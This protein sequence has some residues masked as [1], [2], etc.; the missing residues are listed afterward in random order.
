MKYREFVLWCGE[1]ATD[2]CWDFETAT[3]CIRIINVMQGIPFRKKR[4]A[5]REI[6]DSVEKA[7]VLPINKKIRDLKGGEAE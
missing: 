3:L 6:Q 4:K 1:R 2:G 7:T 5:W